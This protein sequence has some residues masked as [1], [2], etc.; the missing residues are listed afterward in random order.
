MR[1]GV[2]L[3]D[4]MLPPSTPQTSLD[5]VLDA[6]TVQFEDDTGFFAFTRVGYCVPLVQ[7]AHSLPLM[8]PPG[9]VELDME[10]AYSTELVP[11]QT[12]FIGSCYPSADSED[13]VAT[14]KRASETAVSDGDSDGSENCPQ[15]SLA[16]DVAAL[17]V[18]TSG[19]RVSQ[20]DDLLTDFCN[21]AREFELT[22]VRGRIRSTPHLK[23][24]QS[25]GA[26]CAAGIVD[27]NALHHQLCRAF[28]AAVGRTIADDRLLA[29]HGYH[30]DGGPTFVDL[31]TR[32]V[33]RETKLLLG[34][35]RRSSQS[36]ACAA[37][38]MPTAQ[39][40]AC[41]SPGCD[42]QS[43]AAVDL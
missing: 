26:A 27:S 19:T 14:F 34:G 20:L 39:P 5:S 17:A 18:F 7:P 3:L 21:A 25:L 29:Q 22:A 41:E 11:P 8:P 30:D 43:T 35:L 23:Y 15:S 32:S 13:V 6:G 31:L 37:T 16:A 12:Q 9:L 24:R 2:L 10:G 42:E 4:K 40:V 28:G 1:I 38:S 33:A 36:R